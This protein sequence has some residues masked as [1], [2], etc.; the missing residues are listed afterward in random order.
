MNRDALVGIIIV[1]T[2]VILDGIY[3]GI[4]EISDIGSLISA[5]NMIFLELEDVH[6]KLLCG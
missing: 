5:N 1:F 6:Q 3:L 4:N 2:M